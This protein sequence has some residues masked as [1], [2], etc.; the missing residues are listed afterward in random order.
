LELELCPKALVFST[1]SDLRAAFVSGGSPS[2]ETP[3]TPRRTF[4]ID[5]AIPNLLVFALNETRLLVG[6]TQGPITVFDTAPLFSAGS[7]PVHPLHVFQSSSGTP[8]RLILPNPGDMLSLVAV[9]REHNVNDPTAQTVEVLNLETMEQVAGWRGGNTPDT[10]PTT[11]MLSFLPRGIVIT[12][13]HSVLV[14]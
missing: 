2:E 9:L 1:L 7:D 8:P 14:T 4:S 6:L 10:T 12:P 3:F 13:L 5:T 11:C